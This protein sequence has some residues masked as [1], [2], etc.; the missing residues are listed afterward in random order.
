ML[1]KREFE[2]KA[3]QEGFD[4][5]RNAVSQYTYTDTRTAY[6]M[7]RAGVLSALPEE[8]SPVVQMEILRALIKDGDALDIYKAIRE[9]IINEDV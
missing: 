5:S 4:I 7:F 9:C 2:K 6:R 1:R 8:P 3:L